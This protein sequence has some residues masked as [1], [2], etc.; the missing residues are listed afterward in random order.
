MKKCIVSLLLCVIF[1][2]SCGSVNRLNTFFQK[3]SV[4]FSYT[5]IKYK[6]DP[7]SQSFEQL[8]GS[9]KGMIIT[10]DAE[11]CYVTYGDYT[12]NTDPSV[13]AAFKAFDILWRNFKIDFE[14]AVLSDDN[15]F[16]LIV[17]SFRFLVYYNKDS[18]IVGKMVAETEDGVFEYK[19]S[20]QEE[21]G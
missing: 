3:E 12:L 6:Y 9:L 1:L 20:E 19:L 21:A 5:G 14:N 2:C 4:V 16:V 10:F 17:D 15:A 18:E 11:N 13:F 7:S 8:N